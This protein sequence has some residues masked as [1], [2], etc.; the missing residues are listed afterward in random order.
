MLAGRPSLVLV[1]RLPEQRDR[2]QNPPDGPFG[3]VTRACLQISQLGG[4]V[5]VMDAD[6][7]E[8]QRLISDLRSGDSQTAQAFFDHYG[9]LLERLAERHLAS[10]IRRR[11]GA[12]D[13]VQSACR[14]FFR[15]KS[16]Q[17]QL[18]DS[19]SLW[20]LLSAITLA[21]VREQAR[22]QLRKKRGLNQEQHL[23]SHASTDGHAFDAADGGIGPDEAVAFEE[24]FELLVGALDDEERRL[25]DL[26]L[27]EFTNA[28]AAQR[29]GCSERTVR[30]LMKRIQ[31]QLTR[32][33][34]GS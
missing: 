3:N 32:Q 15:H 7:A 20:H 5:P 17:F 18:N 1:G 34:E 2:G 10:G 6:D 4:S 30:R 21:K 31:A 8:F 24:Q 12:D 27:Q 16:G 14:T 13:V 22:F 26:K 9:P 29:L 25:V 33:L 11:V 28:E 19:E 23:E